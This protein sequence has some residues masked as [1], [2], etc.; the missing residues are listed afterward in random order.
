MKVGAPEKQ[1]TNRE[2]FTCKP[3]NLHG[4]IITF[5]VL[6]TNSQN[7]NLV[8]FYVPWYV[9]I[10]IACIAIKI[11]LLLQNTLYLVA[12]LNWFAASAPPY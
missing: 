4:I 5:L 7:L 12:K 6:V 9:C 10:H 2:I 11:Y 1:L 3:T 8:S